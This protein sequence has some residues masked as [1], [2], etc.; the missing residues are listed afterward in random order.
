ML[1]HLARKPSHKG[2]TIGALAINGVFHSWCLEDEIRE[3]PGKPVVE[4]KVYGKTAIP[5]GSYPVILT[6]SARFKRVLPLLVGVPGFSGV[7]CHPGN[8]AEDSDG[9]LLPGYTRY[10]N[11]VGQSRAAFEAL[12]DRLEE[13][14]KAGETIQIHIENPYAGHQV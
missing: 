7:R 2:A 5:Q 9:C 3:V 12:F 10:E 11:S 14:T 13:A 6:P 8:S 1:L 4:W